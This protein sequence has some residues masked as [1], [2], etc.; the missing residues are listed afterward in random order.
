MLRTAKVMKKERYLRHGIF[1]ATPRKLEKKESES[2]TYTPMLTAPNANILSVDDVPINLKVFKALLKKT[3]IN[4]DVADSGS[5][6]LEMCKNKK[7][8]II[9]MDHMM[10]VMDGIETFKELKKSGGLN[11]DTPVVVFTANAISGSE[12]KYMSYGFSA[13]LTKPVIYEEL[14]KSIIKFLPDDKKEMM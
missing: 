10:P 14:E 9:Y 5:A 4:I 2:K 12:E 6:C 1:D 7:Y 13:Y 8:D 11:S 3:K